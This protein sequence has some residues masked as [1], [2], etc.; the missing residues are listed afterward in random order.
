MKK[1]EI[2]KAVKNAVKTGNWFIR[3]DNDGTSYNFF[4]WQPVGKWTTAKD[5]IDDNNCGHGLHGQ[6]HKASG[7]R[8]EGN[9]LV[10]CE[11]KGK[12]NKIG[13]DKIKVKKARILLINELPDNLKVSGSL[14]LNGCTGLKSLPDNLKHKV[15]K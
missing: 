11:T 1:T 5:W 15:I 4:Q 7:F 3:F 6:S 14:A 8:G 2:Q 13:S 9:R 12:R 10:F